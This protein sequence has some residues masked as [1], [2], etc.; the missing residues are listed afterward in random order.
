M[1][2][3]SF[4]HHYQDSKFSQRWP[5]PSP[6]MLYPFTQ[7]PAE[8]G[9]SHFT[10]H[11]S[12]LMLAAALSSA[13]LKGEKWHLLLSFENVTIY[14]C[15]SCVLWSLVSLSCF[16]FLEQPVHIL[17]PFLY[18]DWWGFFKEAFGNEVN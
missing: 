13:S 14:S 3:G 5:Y 1:V 11:S 6:Q 9:G 12:A 2:N 4:Y 18:L 8:S 10:A 7:P 16:L 17:C 15:V